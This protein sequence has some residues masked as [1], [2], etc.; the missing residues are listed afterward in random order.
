MFNFVI[1][2]MLAAQLSKIPPEFRA[3]IEA[4]IEKDPQTML[5]MAQDLQKEMQVGKSQ[6]DALKVIAEKYG[7]Q[8]K[9]LM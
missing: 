4:M 7:E 6:E 1:K 9:G 5:A 2:K 3:K 8:L